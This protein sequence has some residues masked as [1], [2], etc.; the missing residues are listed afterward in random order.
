MNVNTSVTS[1]KIQQKHYFFPFVILCPL[2][3]FPESFSEF[4]W[5]RLTAWLPGPRRGAGH[6]TGAALSTDREE[7]ETGQEEA[8]QNKINLVWRVWG[9]I[10]RYL[11]PDEPEPVTSFPIVFRI[12]IPSGQKLWMVTTIGSSEVQCSSTS[13]LI[14]QLRLWQLTFPGG[15]NLNLCR[16]GQNLVIYG[17]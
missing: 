12:W 9:D 5:S 4:L 8:K 10:S 3:T 1:C 6:G 16:R 14:V 11:L 2:K 17:W 13:R 15:E 7:E